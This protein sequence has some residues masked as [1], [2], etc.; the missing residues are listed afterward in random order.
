MARESCS[1]CQRLWGLY[2]SATL[3]Q[4]RLDR[5]HYF[6][7]LS[8]ETALLQGLKAALDAATVVKESTHEAIRKHKETHHNADAAAV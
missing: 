6:A 3:E 1:E 8:E 4:V 5:Q 2:V 7:C